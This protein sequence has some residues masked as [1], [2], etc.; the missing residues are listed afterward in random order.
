MQ[1]E[2]EMTWSRLSTS[3]DAAGGSVVPLHVLLSHLGIRVSADL[4]IVY[5]KRMTSAGSRCFMAG[6][7]LTSPYRC[8][9]GKEV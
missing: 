4:S 1:E 9:R 7:L 5:C 6:A 8:K 2:V 3:S